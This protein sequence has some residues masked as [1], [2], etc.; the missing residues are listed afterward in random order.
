MNN[1]TSRLSTTTLAATL[2]LGAS[3]L[4]A[5]PATA[6]PPDNASCTGQAVSGGAQNSPVPFGVIVSEYGKY[7]GDEWGEHISDEARTDGEC[8]PPPPFPGT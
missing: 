1:W 5:A 8:P 4:G 2:A 3:A 6:T 7:Y